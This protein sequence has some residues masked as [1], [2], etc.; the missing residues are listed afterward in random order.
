MVDNFEDLLKYQRMMQ[1][2]IQQEQSED[3][4]IEIL[5]I[6]NELAPHPGQRIQKEMVLVEAGIRG[7]PS[8]VAQKL[9]DQLKKD[10]VI[11]EPMVGWLQKR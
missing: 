3:E 9:I 6:I 10:R 1:E 2:R 7:I 5:T 8:D 11:F 4:T